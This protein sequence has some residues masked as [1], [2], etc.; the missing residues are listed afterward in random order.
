MN[1]RQFSSP[2]SRRSRP[3][4]PSTNPCA[5]AANSPA[6]STPPDIRNR[7]PP[8][9][10]SDFPE[11]APPTAAAALSPPLFAAVHTAQ[12]YAASPSAAAPARSASKAPAYPAPDGSRRIALARLSSIPCSS[13]VAIAPFQ[14]Q[15]HGKSTEVRPTPVPQSPAKLLQSPQ[16]IPAKMYFV[17]SCRLLLANV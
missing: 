16:N 1:I 5:G 12:P 15:S 8:A 3:R 6:C 4:M 13:M 10:P 17:I 9:R 11:F 14:Y 7:T 2:D